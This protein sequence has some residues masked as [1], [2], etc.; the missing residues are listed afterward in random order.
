V[1]PRIGGRDD[2]AD[3]ADR[4]YRCGRPE[5]ALRPS[6]NVTLDFITSI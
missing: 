1:V 4:Q 6:P 5:T 2:T 3:V